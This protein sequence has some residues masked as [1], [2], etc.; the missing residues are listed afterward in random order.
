M[1]ATTLG[2]WN[3][4]REV[5]KG[6]VMWKASKEVHTF[7]TYYFLFLFFFFFSFF[8]MDRFLWWGFVGCLYS[9]YVELG[10][11]KWS[12]KARSKCVGSVTS[13]DWS[14][15]ASGTLPVC[16]HHG[17]WESAESPLGGACSLPWAKRKPRTITHFSNYLCW[18]PEVE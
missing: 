9:G 11:W 18:V 7:R 8:R 2:F 12:Y 13:P 5:E 10:P 14:L 15:L 1:V 16:L 6:W 3:G 17:R 4:K